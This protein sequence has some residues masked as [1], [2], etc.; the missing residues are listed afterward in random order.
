MQRPTTTLQYQHPLFIAGRLSHK[1]QEAGA[2]ARWL[3]GCVTAPGHRLL[4][5]L[6]ASSVS[7]EL[8]GFKRAT[9][10]PA[11]CLVSVRLATRN[12]EGS[13]IFGTACIYTVRP[14]GLSREQE[15]LSQ[16]HHEKQTP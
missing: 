10:S 9:T 11:H 2:E 13:K 14:A 1:T 16:E 6:H 5:T 15:D 4:P 3:C 7:A 8:P 12:S